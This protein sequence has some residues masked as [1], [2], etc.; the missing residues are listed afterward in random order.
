VFECKAV[1]ASRIRVVAGVMK[2]R[3]H[4]E[5][6]LLFHGLGV[7][8]S[9]LRD[10]DSFTWRGIAPAAAKSPDSKLAVPLN[11]CVLSHGWV[12]AMWGTG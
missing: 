5:R 7:W 4:Y 6:I 9:G 3:P 12:A 2:L 11:A 8:G 10:G 1:L